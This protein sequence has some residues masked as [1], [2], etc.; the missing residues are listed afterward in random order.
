MRNEAN[1][2][3]TIESGS[4]GVM[5]SGC[6]SGSVMMLIPA[7]LVSSKSAQ[8]S[9]EKVTHLR[10]GRGFFAFTKLSFN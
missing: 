7:L 2:I 3:L 4:L 10:L 9:N 8:R 5:G 6:K 1:G